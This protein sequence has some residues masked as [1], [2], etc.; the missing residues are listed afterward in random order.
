[1]KYLIYFLMLIFLLGIVSA[2]TQICVDF[3]KPSAPQSLTYTISN[4]DL[5]LN[6]VGATD[7]PECSGIAK[8]EIYRNL[9]KIGESP[10]TFFIDEQLEEGTYEYQIYAIDKAQHKS[11]AL[12]KEIITRTATSTVTHHSSSGNSNSG[13]N[14][15]QTNNTNQTYENLSLG[16]NGGEIQGDEDLNEVA[17][18]KD[19]NSGFL[20][21]VIGAAENVNPFKSI[22]ATAF[23]IV[24]FLGAIGIFIIRRIKKSTK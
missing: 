6:W 12:T 5:I 13:D 17:D 20:G 15:N 18:K 22:L 10:G 24:I 7:T 3:D 16:N 1:M 21:A 8:Y 9:E 19:I 23:V 14:E 4:G 11:E 2:E